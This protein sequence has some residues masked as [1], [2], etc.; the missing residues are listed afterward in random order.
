MINRHFLLIAI[1]TLGLFGCGASTQASY[2]ATDTT[3]NEWVNGVA[4]DWATGFFVKNTQE[5]ARD[6]AVGKKVLLADGSIRAVTGNRINGGDLIVFL[7]GS[8]LD[9]KLVGYPKILKPYEKSN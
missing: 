5:A 2:S 9:G 1:L 4:R 6:F 3:N 8:P 7:E